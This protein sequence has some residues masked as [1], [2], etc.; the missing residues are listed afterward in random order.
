M[1]RADE[2][3][4]VRPGLYF[5]QAYEPAVKV[6]LSCCACRTRHGLVFVDPIPLAKLALEELLEAGPAAA[7]VLTNGNH[8][9]AAAEYRKRL[10]I[11]IYAHADAVQELGL[12]V[13][14]LVS[15]GETVMD[16]LTVAH[17]PGSAVGEIALSGHG[18]WHLGDALI[19]LPPMGFSLLP[20]KYCD[21]PKELRRSVEKL[22]RIPFEVLTFAHGLPIVAHAR[23]RL[24][25]LLA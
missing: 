13:D 17:L 10:S 25:Q 5:W 1:A 7:I 16:E 8:A 20:D 9:R 24:S 18:T 23:Q 14:H 4:E 22:L 2:I 11:P 6:E 21:D 12:A 19:H 3:H 15:D